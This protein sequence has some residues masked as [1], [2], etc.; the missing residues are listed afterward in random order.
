M[1][2]GTLL[3]LCLLAMAFPFSVM[4][5]SQPAPQLKVESDE[6]GPIPNKVANDYYESCLYHIPSRF[7]PQAR[8]HYCAC[9]SAAVQGNF[10]MKDFTALQRQANRKVGNPVFDKYVLNTVVP[11]LDTPVRQIEYL[12]CLVDYSVDIRVRHV[13]TYC[14]CVALKMQKHA[15]QFADVEIMTQYGR[16]SSNYKDPVQ[17]LWNN[18]K[19]IQAK[20]SARRD[21]IINPN[22]Q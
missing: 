15:V 22:S 8:E 4:A 2:T 18:P 17:A 13:P 20:T 6:N 5:N 21:C 3:L 14:N 7:T 1:K 19:Y 12:A 16:Y 10:L 11:C 9:H